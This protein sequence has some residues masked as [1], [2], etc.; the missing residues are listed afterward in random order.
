MINSNTIPDVLHDLLP[1]LLRQKSGKRFITAKKPLFVVGMHQAHANPRWDGSRR[2]P[3]VRRASSSAGPG[4]CSASPEAFVEPL[5]RMSCYSA[6]RPALQPRSVGRADHGLSLFIRALGR[7]PIVAR[8]S[9]SPSGPP[10]SRDLPSTQRRALPRRPLTCCSC[11]GHHRLLLAPIF[12]SP[13][14]VTS[15][16]IPEARPW[17]L[18][19]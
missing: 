12:W 14:R 4:L 10:S 8:S 9:P 18:T 2:Q 1:S 11:T 13:P 17:R 7:L 19:T 6:F 5:N 16:G 3:A 15:R